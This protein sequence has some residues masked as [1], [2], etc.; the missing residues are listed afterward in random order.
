MLSTENLKQE[1][2]E[3]IKDSQQE[4]EEEENA[5]WKS[6]YKD[7]AEKMLNYEN[8]KYE[9]GKKIHEWSPLKFY[10]NVNEAKTG[11]QK[12]KLS[13][14]YLGQIVADIII[15]DNNIIID[16]TPYDSKNKEFGDV[17]KLEKVDWNSTQAKQFRKYFRMVKPKRLNINKKNEEHRLESQL[18]TEFLKNNSINKLLCG[19]QPITFAGFR[20]PMPTALKASKEIKFGSG[21]ID[22]LARTTGHKITVIELKDENVND[23]PIDKV[24]KQATA[25]AVFLIKLLRSESGKEWYKIFGFKGDIPKTLRIKVCG[26]MPFKDDN[27]YDQFES[28]ELNCGDDI[29]EYHWL[30]F[31]EENGEII[32]IESNLN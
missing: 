1:L 28:F 19:I 2:Q 13:V 5:I 24:L 14:R 27:T 12:L 18:L 7:Y 21:H 17:P 6:R 25:Y 4:L 10:L 16:T 3:K 9:L 26:A 20:L 8:K 23:E 22:I 30:Y 31:K 11:K 15:D 32:E 29:L